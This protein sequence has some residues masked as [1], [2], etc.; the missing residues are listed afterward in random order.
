MLLH[1]NPRQKR[2]G[3]CTLL[4]MLPR[5]FAFG[6]LLQP[7]IMLRLCINLFRVDCLHGIVHAYCLL[8]EGCLYLRLQIILA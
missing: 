7:S 3:L 1:F 6:N 4:F 5:I 8:Y 2:V